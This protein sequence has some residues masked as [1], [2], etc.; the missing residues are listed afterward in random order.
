MRKRGVTLVEMMVGTFILSMI[1]VPLYYILKEAG[2]KRS[3]VACKDFVKQE[4][5]KVLKILE[6][7]LSQARRQSFKQTSDDVYEIKVRKEGDDKDVSLRYVFIPP[8]LKRQF[9][10][11]E[12]VI[13][14]NIDEFHVTTT[15]DTPGRLVVSLKTSASF[16][17]IKA[18]EAPSLSQEKMIVMREDAAYERD[19]HWRDVGDVNKFFAS[20]GSL[21]GGIKSDAKKLVKDFTGEFTAA[22]KDIAAM[23]VGELQKI[24]DDLFGG[25][26]DV[27]SS[28]KGLDDDILDLDAK[29]LYDTNCTG[30][31][32][33]S[34]KEKAKKV[35]NALAAMD[36]KDK[37]DWNKIKEIGGGSS[38]FSSGMKTDAIKEMYNAKMELFNSGQEIVKQIDSFSQMAGEKGLK[39]DTSSINR[40]KWGA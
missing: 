34:K 32:S 39:I 20:Q 7:D 15:P 21:M 40:S 24:K 27:E 37:M 12:W 23:T 38:F 11:K 36:T 33:D 16:E 31:L 29:A 18:D 35:K 19:K 9:D 14:K 6:N 13:S 5:T 25:L 8:D 3:L 10:G 2:Q 26:K 17:G 22:G 4:S 1:S 28:I 30:S